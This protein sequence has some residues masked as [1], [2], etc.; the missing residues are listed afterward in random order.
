MQRRATGGTNLFFA[1]AFLGVSLVTGATSVFGATRHSAQHPHHLIRP[2]SSHS[3]HRRG[4]SARTV[5]WGISCVPYARSQSGIDLPGNARD[6][7]D[8]ASG[9]YARGEIPRPGAV[10]A[11]RAN[12]RMR[13]GHVAVVE[14]VI[15]RREIEVDQANWGR[16]G[17]VSHDVAV[18]DVSE[19]NDW[20]AV[21]V[22]MGRGDDFGA[23][24]PTYG[25]IYN[26]P[27]KGT[28]VTATATPAPTPALNPVTIDL[29]TPAERDDEVAEAP[30]VD[31]PVYSHHAKR[32][33]HTKIVAH[34]VSTRY[35]SS[36][37]S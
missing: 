2:T 13:L 24:Y 25:F 34:H 37:Q 8:N 11:F 9:L 20:S 7:W 33:R 23:I 22:E 6:W 27:D 15:N 1:S 10:L 32:R 29:R 28:I 4:Y 21:R 31:Q 12:A 5:A 16:A 35:H 36:K 3:S 26:Q 19:E 18:V 14:N 30:P 17:R